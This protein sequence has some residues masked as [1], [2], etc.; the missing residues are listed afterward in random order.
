MH[1]G[2]YVGI[3]LNASETALNTDLKPYLNTADFGLALG[4][5][6]KIPLTDKLKLFIEDDGQAGVLNILNSN[7]NNSGTATNTRTAL[8]IGVLFSVK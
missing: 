7:P 5:G 2:P 4:I 8:N 3:L 1:F 6:V